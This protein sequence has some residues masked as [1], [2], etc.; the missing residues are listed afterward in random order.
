MTG[1]PKFGVAFRLIGDIG[2]VSQKLGEHILAGPLFWESSMKRVTLKGGRFMVQ[3]L[4]RAYAL[5]Y[6]LN[7]NTDPAG[8]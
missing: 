5:K 3:S 1:F 2:R 4:S 8:P 7:S 6:P